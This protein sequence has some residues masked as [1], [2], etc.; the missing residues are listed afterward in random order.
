MSAAAAG[1]PAPRSPQRPWWA[2]LGSVVPR[3]VATAVRA[4]RSGPDSA[5]PPLAANPL[6]WATLAVDELTVSAAYLLTRRSA[7]QVSE[8]AV[9]DA[10]PP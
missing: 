10:K 2:E 9:A 1:V 5:T 3:T 8:Q 6:T 4:T 7:E